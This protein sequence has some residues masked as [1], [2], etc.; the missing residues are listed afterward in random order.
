MAD[1][2]IVAPP[3][4]LGDALE[5]QRLAHRARRIELATLALRQTAQTRDPT[6]PSLLRAISRFDAQL[7]EIR[8]RLTE[9][10]PACRDD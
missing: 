4:T 8:E 10:G 2:P 9:L 5:R 7:A 6:P 1:T 3:Q